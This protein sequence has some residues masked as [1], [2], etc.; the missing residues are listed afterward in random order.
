MDLVRTKR[1]TQAMTVAF[2]AVLVLGIALFLLGHQVPGLILIIVSV[3]VLVIC[4]AILN[5]YSLYAFNYMV[6]RGKMRR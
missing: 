2:V 1:I 3:A 5:F 6:N 4:F